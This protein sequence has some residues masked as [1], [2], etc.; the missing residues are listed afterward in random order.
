MLCI[1]IGTPP[2]DLQHAILQTVGGGPAHD[3]GALQQPPSQYTVTEAVDY[4][5][6]W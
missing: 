4:I 3:T 5:G 2:A 6:M 1:T